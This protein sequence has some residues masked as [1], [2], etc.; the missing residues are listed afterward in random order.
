V[1]TGLAARARP[2][3]DIA[4]SWTP[5]PSRDGTISY[6]VYDKDVTARDTTF[7]PA[8]SSALDDNSATVASLTMGH[9]Y[10]FEVSAGT[11]APSAPVTAVPEIGPPMALTA[12]A[13]AD[14]S[15]SLA[16]STP[17]PSDWYWIYYCDVTS[18][19]SGGCRTPVLP[20]KDDYTRTVYPDST[21][22]SFDFTGLTGGH[23]YRFY[24]TATVAS[25]ESAPSNVATA[26]V[27]ATAVAAPPTA[28]AGM[29]ATP[30]DDAGVSLS[31]TAPSPSDWYWVWYRDDTI[32]GAFTK[33]KD[34]DD[35]NTFTADYLY[36]GHQYSYYVQ[37]ISPSGA[38]S[39]ASSTASATVTLAAP[40]NLT[41]TAG[42]GSV[43]LTWRPPLPSQWYW[44]YMNGKRLPDA[45]PETSISLGDLVNG[46]TYT[47]YV[48][49]AAPGGQGESAP[50]NTVTATPQAT[51]PAIPT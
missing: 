42:D 31:W 8:V 20:G 11:G 5:L 39:V 36:V 47:F 48:T 1:P 50:S 22:T 30:N 16:W 26:T 18:P 37:A 4:L 32:G 33:Y 12:T 43:Q 2:D 46:T 27:T 21:G 51:P 24:V 15:V 40:S 10:E 45:V 38:T 41:V 49:T 25:G 28:P 44:I 3:G 34:P 23:E 29:T 35:R 7:S 13:D 14:G 9:T 17:D 6:H 19:P